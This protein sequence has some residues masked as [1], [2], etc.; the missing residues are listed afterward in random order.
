MRPATR[1]VAVARAWSLDGALAVSVGLA[2]AALV[3]SDTYVELPFL[4]NRLAMLH[5]MPVLAGM[6][7]GFPLVDRMPELAVLSPRSA[8]RL[9]ALRVAAVALVSLPVAGALVALGWTVGGASVVLGFVGVAAACAAVLRLWYWAPM[10]A[11]LVAWAYQGPGYLSGVAGPEWGEPALA[12][13]A[14][15]AALYVAVEA[16][17]VRRVVRGVGEDSEEGRALDTIRP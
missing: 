2:V 8:L 6:A 4:R 5:L 17:R 7:L 12:S 13:L 11:V 3:T 10:F 9:P 1:A 16:W 14:L 15:G